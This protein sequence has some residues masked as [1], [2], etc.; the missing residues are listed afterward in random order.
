MAGQSW[1]T[2]IAVVGQAGRAG[3]ARQWAEQ[4]TASGCAYRHSG[5]VQYGENIYF[6]SPV[7]W[8]DGKAE[9]QKITPQHVVDNWGQESKEY[10]YASNS[11]SGICGHYTQLVWKDSR[12][13]GC[14]MAVCADKAQLWVCN[15][16]P[17]G[18]QNN[19]RPY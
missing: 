14:G 3:T 7:I 13:V 5:R 11:C 12:E 16:F 4:L 6:A 15:Y 8:S 10:D 2:C 19:Q 9:M 17:E 18:N 1:R